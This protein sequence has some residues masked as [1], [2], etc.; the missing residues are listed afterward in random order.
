MELKAT[1]NEKLLEKNPL[2]RFKEVS[3]FEWQPFRVSTNQALI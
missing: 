2:R 3:L 1:F